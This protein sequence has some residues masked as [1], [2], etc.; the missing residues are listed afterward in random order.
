MRLDAF[1]AKVVF[2]ADSV[3]VI[4][5]SGMAVTSKVLLLNVPTLAPD[6][7]STAEIDEPINQLASDHS[8]VIVTHRMQGERVYRTTR[9]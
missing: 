1:L 9:H 8:T 2:L 5:S 6:P 4:A 7:I 3:S